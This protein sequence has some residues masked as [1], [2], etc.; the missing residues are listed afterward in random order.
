[1]RILSILLFTSLCCQVFANERSIFIIGEAELHVPTSKTTI[2]V[3]TTSE[4]EQLH[5]ALNQSISNRQKFVAKL[6]EKGFTDKQISGNSENTI[7]SMK[8]YSGK[9]K[10]YTITKQLRIEIKNKDELLYIAKLI[11]SNE[12][13]YFVR[14]NASVANED[15][16]KSELSI[17]AIE[18]GKAK[19]KKIEQA[20][21]LTYT[22]VAVHPDFNPKPNME[23]NSL[24]NTISIFDAESGYNANSF[25]KVKGYADLPYQSSIGEDNLKTYRKVLYLEYQIAPITLPKT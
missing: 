4:N 25:S 11:D 3:V 17:K 9:T 23:K 13:L 1:M 7:P 14:T 15:S 21:G 2:T 18:H 22:L 19:I 6:L 24:Y 16:I 20:T 5:V 8:R 12:D 10:S